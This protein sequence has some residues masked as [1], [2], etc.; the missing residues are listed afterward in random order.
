MTREEI[1]NAIMEGKAKLDKATIVAQLLSD[2]DVKNIK[3]DV[4][5][6]KTAKRLADFHAQNCVL[7]YKGNE[8]AFNPRGVEGKEIIV[9]TNLDK[10]AIVYATRSKDNTVSISVTPKVWNK[11][12]SGASFAKALVSANKNKVVKLVETATNGLS[13]D[14]FYN[15]CTTFKGWKLLACNGVYKTIEV[16][17]VI[18]EAT[19]E[20]EGN[21]EK[22]S[23]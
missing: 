12:N 4:K 2:E 21:A 6:R 15:K 14:A 5:E 22:V 17:P 23:A 1:V 8:I 7:T 19:P 11:K 18:K 16:K 10:N 13:F 20:K 3:A 9:W